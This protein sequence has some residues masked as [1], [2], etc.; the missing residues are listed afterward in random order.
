LCKAAVNTL[1]D[2]E[3]EEQLLAAEPML[4]HLIGL[5]VLVPEN[6]ASTTG[7]CILANG[8][9]N[10]CTQLPRGKYAHFKLRI[11]LQLLD[12]SASQMQQRLPY[13][14][15][16]VDSN[17][18]LMAGSREYRGDLLALMEILVTDV[19]E[20]ISQLQELKGHTK[21]T[22]RQADLNMAL[23]AFF[24]LKRVFDEQSEQVNTLARKIVELCRAREAKAPEVLIM[25]LALR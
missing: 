7:Y 20:F 24:G 13:H 3:R 11:V 1:G 10:A 22:D 14:I 15:L 25:D 17:D 8:C 6:P 23:R 2:L 5:L 16:R 9:Y 21:V 18:Y 19:V 12:F 4:N